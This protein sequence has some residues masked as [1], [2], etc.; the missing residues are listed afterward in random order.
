MLDIKLQDIKI[1]YKCLVDR[2]VQRAFNTWIAL[3][4][5]K[6]SSQSRS[7]MASLQDIWVRLGTHSLIMLFAKSTF[8][9]WSFDLHS[10]NVIFEGKFLLQPCFFLLTKHKIWVLHFQN[11]LFA[12]LMGFQM[13]TTSYTKKEKWKRAKQN[14]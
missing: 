7:S 2:N 9:K 1:K 11:V 13:D 5:Q 3:E 8:W 10:Q 4:F 6:Q 14:K 12:F